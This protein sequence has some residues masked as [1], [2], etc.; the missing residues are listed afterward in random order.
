VRPSSPARCCVSRRT[1]ALALAVSLFGNRVDMAK[2]AWGVLD[3]LG[4][5]IRPAIARFL[6]PM[7]L[8]FRVYLWQKGICSKENRM[9]CNVGEDR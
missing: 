7:A 6:L 8:V 9:Y 1:V 2:A 5:A 4:Q 3:A